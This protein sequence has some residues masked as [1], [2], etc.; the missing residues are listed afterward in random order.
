[1]DTLERQAATTPDQY[2]LKEQ[3]LHPVCSKPLLTHS[4]E[5][6][7]LFRP[8]YWWIFHKSSTPNAGFF[9][10]FHI[11]SN[12][13]SLYVSCVV[14]WCHPPW[15]FSGP[16]AHALLSMGVFFDELPSLLYL[17]MATHHLKI[18]QG[19]FLLPTFHCKNWKLP[20]GAPVLDQRQPRLNV[21]RNPC[22]VL[23]Q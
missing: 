12:E 14:M 11:P 17:Y 20:Q 3:I 15:P 22:H 18:T 5:T 6:L 13:F 19:D 9:D 1:M 10:T 16:L 4:G 7:L 8:G 2:C 21:K 23:H